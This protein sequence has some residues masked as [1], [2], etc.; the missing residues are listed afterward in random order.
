MEY[1]LLVAWILVAILS[2]YAVDRIWA[3]VVGQGYR[4]FMIPGVV[5]HELS[6][7]AACLVVGAKISRITVF[8]PEGGSVVHSEPRVPV[9]GKPI[10]SMAPIFGCG[11]ALWLCWWALGPRVT[12]ADLPAHVTFTKAGLAAF[13]RGVVDVAEDALRIF[14]KSDWRS[15]RTYVFIYLSVTL[16]ISLCPSR[17]DFRNAALGLVAMGLGVWIADLA[18]RA[19]GRKPG[20]AD[21][22]VEPI[23]PFVT[24]VVGMLMFVL[25][26]STG[27]WIVREMVGLIVRKGRNQA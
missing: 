24:F 26:V 3:G 2:A 15:W 12:L 25:A 9:I 6:H 4:I 17:R 23:W 13:T 8:D 20:L 11:F 7:A 10:V 21:I 18:A 14:T 16:A 1:L 5:V 27:V 19:A 22:L